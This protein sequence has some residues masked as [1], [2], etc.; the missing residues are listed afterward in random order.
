MIDKKIKRKKERDRLTGGKKAIDREKAIYRDRE[1][2]RDK[3]SVKVY[4][5]FEKKRV[6]MRIKRQ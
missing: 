5:I 1:I 2:Y 6:K 4:K 3:E